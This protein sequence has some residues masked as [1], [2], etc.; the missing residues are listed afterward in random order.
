MRR[1]PRPS[2]ASAAA[3]I[4]VAAV[5]VGAVTTAGNRAKPSFSKAADANAAFCFIP[6]AWSWPLDLYALVYQITFNASWICRAGVAV[7][8]ISPALA[9]GFSAYGLV[10]VTTPLNILEAGLA[11]FV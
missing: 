3:A 10:S 5:A 9:S 7:A 8:V 11:K 6:C 1:V 2:E 4:G